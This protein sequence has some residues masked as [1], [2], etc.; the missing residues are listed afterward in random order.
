MA[1]SQS[2]TIRQIFWVESGVPNA[3]MPWQMP[4]KPNR[5]NSNPKPVWHYGHSP[6]SAGCSLIFHRPHQRRWVDLILHQLPVESMKS[7]HQHQLNII[8]CC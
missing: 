2:F 5:L 3:I 1:T 8:L 6:R 4:G 7:P